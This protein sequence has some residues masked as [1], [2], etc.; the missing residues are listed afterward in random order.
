MYL[1]K[2]RLDGKTALV[3]GGGRGIGLA[4][5]HAFAEAGATVVISDHD[6]DLLASGVAMLAAAGHAAHAV[7][8]DVTKSDDVEHQ[9][10]EVNRTVGP[11]DVLFANAGIAWPDTP[12]EEMSDELWSRMI[13]V[14]L[15][16]VFRC[17]RSFG[18]HMLRRGRGSIVVTGSMSGIISNRPQRQVHYNAAKAGVHHLVRSLAG[19][20]GERGVRVN[21]VAPGYIDN[22]I[23]GPALRIP[24]LGGVWL[25][26][27]PMRRGGLVEEIASIALFLASDASSL[28][29]GSIVVA[30]AGYCVW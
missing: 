28:M 13:D 7:M 17:C 2:F 16:G 5:A 10:N 26:N 8:L 1:E 11:V 30:D 18:R 21:A 29:T 3:T 12:A 20:W 19:E 22:A 25:E 27:T 23:S 24:E 14:N 15:T 9:A 6:A 4:A